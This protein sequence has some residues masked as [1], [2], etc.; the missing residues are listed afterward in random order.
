MF[1]WNRVAT[2]LLII[3][4]SVI[5]YSFFQEMDVWVKGTAYVILIVVG[6]LNLFFGRKK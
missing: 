3:V 2:I 6:L 5:L 1:T 4:G